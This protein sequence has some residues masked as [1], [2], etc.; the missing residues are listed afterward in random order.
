[1]RTVKLAD[2]KYEYDIDDNGCMA[3]ARR[4]G[5]D[6]PAGFDNRFDNA[7]LAALDR[8]L[9]LEAKP[10]ARVDV[11]LRFDATRDP[12]ARADDAARMHAAGALGSA[13]SD[14]RVHVRGGNLV[15]LFDDGAAEVVSWGRSR[16][17]A[18]QIDLAMWRNRTKRHEETMTAAIDA[19]TPR[20]EPSARWAL[21]EVMGHRRHVGRVSEAR[22]AGAEVLRVEALR[23]D[24]GFDHYSYNPAAIFSTRDVT[25]AEAR[26]EVVPR[27]H[28]ACQAFAPSAVQPAWCR[29]CGHDGPEHDAED[30][31][32]KRAEKEEDDEDDEIPFPT[33]ESAAVIARVAT[34]EQPP[35]VPSE[36]PAIW[37][38]VVED[39]AERFVG[40]RDL[41]AILADMRA[42][43]AL[44]R[45][46]YGTPLQAGNG[47]DALA[48]AYQ[49]A[50]DLAVYLRQ[51]LAEGHFWPAER[52]L[53]GAV[54]DVVV[55]I[56]ELIVDRA[57]QAVSR[58]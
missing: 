40:R 18:E 44:G 26:R 50:L 5:M 55:E 33:A 16:E 39:T 24:G 30:A 9:E 19:Q 32:R 8:I 6:W 37:E 7:F 10:I 4:H 17:L 28:R 22:L 38:M 13:E 34:A 42:R 21:V 43:D 2:G 29:H 15:V 25:E 57:E 46:R 45:Q 27:E 14:A 3:A 48:D 52:R 54:L 58:G 53:Y 23:E 11:G 47:R 41:P 56:H 49:E 51:H 12:Q 31:E 35:P 1:M 36:K 20:I